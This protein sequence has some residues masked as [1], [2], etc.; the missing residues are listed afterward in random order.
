MVHHTRKYVSFCTL[1]KIYIKFSMTMF[2]QHI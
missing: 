1:K 2:S